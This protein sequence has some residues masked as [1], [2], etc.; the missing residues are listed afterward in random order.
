MQLELVEKGGEEDSVEVREAGERHSVWGSG[1]LG[2]GEEKRRRE[3]S[4]KETRGA[5][6]NPGQGSLS[7]G[8]ARQGRLQVEPGVPHALA[9]VLPS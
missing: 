8:G 9:S 2:R 5:W 3:I 7:G 6:P 1:G 4:R